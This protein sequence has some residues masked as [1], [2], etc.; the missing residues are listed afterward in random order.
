M[1]KRLWMI[2]LL[3]LML[4]GCSTEVYETMSDQY[5][6][7]QGLKPAEVLLMLPQEAS[8]MT[9]KE[10][11]D[12]RFYICKDFTLSVQTL[13]AGDLG[14]TLQTVS[15]FSRENI[16]LV[17]LTQ[18]DIRRYECVWVSAGEQEDQICKA[19]ILD[20]GDFHYVLIMQAGAED[21]FALRQTWNEIASTVSLDTG[22]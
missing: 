12:N 17:E 21:A 4:P 2:L 6:Q 20:D 18:G 9:A 16:S 19:V 11:T 22:R 13:P 5:V 1:L 3:C 8:L 10:E 14:K 7:P 15:G